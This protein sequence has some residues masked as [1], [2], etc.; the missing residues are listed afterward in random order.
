ME[1]QV[2]IQ[3]RIDLVMNEEFTKLLRENCENKLLK[4]LIDEKLDDYSLERL[5]EYLGED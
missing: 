4:L 2:V 1:E 5:V 3:E